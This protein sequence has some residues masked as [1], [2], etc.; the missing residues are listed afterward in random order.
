MPDP[1]RSLGAVSWSATGGRT[2]L[3]AAGNSLRFHLA[4]RPGTAI[5][6]LAA[7]AGAH[8]RASVRRERPGPVAGRQILRARSGIGLHRRGRQCFWHACRL[9]TRTRVAQ[10]PPGHGF[11]RGHAAEHPA[12]GQPPVR[13][14]GFGQRGRRD[15][16]AGHRGRVA[17]AGHPARF[18][19]AV[20]R[21][22]RGRRRRRPAR[23]A[24]HFLS[25]ALEG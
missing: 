6:A 4:S 5:R 9:R 10:R 1:T 22:C 19:F 21:Q 24:P 15:R 11:S 12:A 7:G 18:A 14:G 2:S 23:H 13:P 16:D 3:F 20:Y 25:G 17:R 8:S